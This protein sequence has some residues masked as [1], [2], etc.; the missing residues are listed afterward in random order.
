MLT[1]RTRIISQLITIATHM[2]AVVSERRET[3]IAL[4]ELVHCEGSPEAFE[5]LG[6]DLDDAH[7]VL[8]DFTTMQAFGWLQGYAELAGYDGVYDLLNA[9]GITS[10]VLDKI[11]SGEI[12]EA[13]TDTREP[14]P[15][16][17]YHVLKESIALTTRMRLEHGPITIRNTEHDVLDEYARQAAQ[18]LVGL[19]GL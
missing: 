15:A 7:G 9:H 13:P 11:E 10:D 17:I 14:A 1:N 5:D 6:R 4:H 8:D 3:Q 19:L 18:T 16:R 2:R 12:T